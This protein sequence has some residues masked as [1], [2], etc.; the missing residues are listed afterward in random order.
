MFTKLLDYP[1]SRIVKEVCWIIS[2]ICVGTKSQLQQILS[3][4]DLMKK[5]SI[6]FASG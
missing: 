3:H 6:L 4:N 2:N 1:K 5:L